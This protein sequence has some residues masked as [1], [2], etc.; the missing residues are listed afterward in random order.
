MQELVTMTVVTFIHLFSAGIQFLYTKL[1]DEND[2]IERRKELM[3][4]EIKNVCVLFE[5]AR[6][7]SRIGFEASNH[8]Y[9]TLNDLVE[10]VINCKY[11]LEHL[12]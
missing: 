6:R 12:K 3:L 2:D 10:K 4:Q 1:R 11:I 5:I 7:D 8:Y 9:Y